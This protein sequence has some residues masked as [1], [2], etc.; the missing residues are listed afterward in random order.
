MK[1]YWTVKEPTSPSSD[2]D[3]N[4]AQRLGPRASII[5]VY[6]IDLRYVFAVHLLFKVLFY[7]TNKILY[8]FIGG[9][10]HEMVN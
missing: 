8:N 1:Q 3:G 9:L 7:D 4:I 2:F 6:E 10:K 5:E